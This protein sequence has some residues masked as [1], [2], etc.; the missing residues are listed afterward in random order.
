V[1]DDGP[2][3][4]PYRMLERRNMLEQ[5]VVVGP[6]EPD[7]AI[8]LLDSWFEHAQPPRRLAA[9]QRAAI[10]ERIVRPDAT[11]CRRPLYLRILFEEY[12]MW[13]SYWPVAAAQIGSNAAALLNTLLERLERT[14]EHGP[15]VARALGHLA[16]ARRGLSENEIVEVLWKDKDYKEYLDKLN[17]DHGHAFPAGAKRIP[18]AI[19]ARLRQDLAPYLSEHAAHGITVINFY[20]REVGDVVRYRY[21][22]R[23]DDRDEYQCRLADYFENAPI[24]DRTCDELPWLLWQTESFVR[25][26]AC[27]L[28]ID[29]FRKIKKRD[30]NELIGYWVGLGEERTMGKAYIESYQAWSEQA[31][32]DN[33][34][35]AHAAAELGIFLGF[36]GLYAETEWL[37]RRALQ[38]YEQDCDANELYICYTLNTLSSVLKLNNR[39]TEAEQLLRR[40]L[41][42][43][44]QKFGENHLETTHAFNNLAMLLQDTGRLAEAEQLMLRVLKIYEQNLGENHPHFSGALNNMARLLSAADRPVAAEQAM[45]RA[46]RICEYNL[47]E[48]HLEVGGVL[49]NLAVLLQKTD[50]PAEAEP[51]MRR[52]IRILERTLGRDHPVVGG[53]LNQFAMLLQDTG[54]LA[55]AEHRMRRAVRIAE[56]NYGDN[57]PNVAASLNNLAV[58]LQTANRYL[59]AESVSRRMVKILLEFTQDTGSPHPHVWDAIH[60]YVCLLQTMGCSEVGI[61]EMLVSLGWRFGVDLAAMG[62]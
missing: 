50:R 20:Q 32:R 19:W 59:E 48:D 6:L 34:T 15:T 23:L 56:E 53:V 33:L 52:A 25:L 62:P 13:P 30:E 55:E 35:V 37:T 11:E 14:E 49:Y 16:S 17:E 42:I 41:R 57:H 2:M 10:T 3:G 8:T 46:L 31:H 58:L 60:N 45:R 7:K 51:L 4:E 9:S 28:D 38:L 26:R 1:E 27:L 5:A 61:S 54:R 44:Q 24:F 40:V 22:E 36:A 47:G 39:L 29:R 21:L 12:R 18:I 43:Y